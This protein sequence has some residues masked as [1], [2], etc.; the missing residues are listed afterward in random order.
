MTYLKFCEFKRSPLWDGH[1]VVF[2]LNVTL[3]KDFVTVTSVCNSPPS[4]VGGESYTQSIIMRAIL[5]LGAMIEPWEIFGI[6]EGRN[7]ALSNWEKLV[8]DKN[9]Y[10]MTGFQRCVSSEISYHRLELSTVTGVICWFSHS[11]FR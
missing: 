11:S 7:F 6:P 2:M 8:T 1:P 5:Y 10:V 3:S 9:A 4:A